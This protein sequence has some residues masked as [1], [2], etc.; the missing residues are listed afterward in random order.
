MT[1]KILFKFACIYVWLQLVVHWTLVE[2]VHRQ[3]EA[4]R[5]GFESVV[6]LAHLSLFYPE[7][8]N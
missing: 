1:A 4:L 6:P 8:V 7:E 5:E 2:G 3:L